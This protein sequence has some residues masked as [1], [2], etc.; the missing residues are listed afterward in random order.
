[1]KM[2]N[3]PVKK[4]ILEKN[5][6]NVSTHITL[7][8]DL[9]VITVKNAIVTHLDL[10]VCNVVALVTVPVNTLTQ[11]LCAMFVNLGLTCQK[12]FATHAHVMNWVL[13]Y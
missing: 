7:W 10:P 9:M 13:S 5:A 6:M 2:E 1:M 12:A 11:D 4:N 3:V 8:Q